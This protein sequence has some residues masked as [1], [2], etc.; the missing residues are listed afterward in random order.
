M[1]KLREN[2]F[3]LMDESSH[4]SLTE[5]GETIA[6]RMYH[7]HRVLTEMLVRLG[8]SEKNAREDACKIEHDL[9]DESFAAIEKHIE[10]YR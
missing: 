10:M 6:K 2:G 8:V 9:S 3:I 5:A 1:K 7:R 4:I